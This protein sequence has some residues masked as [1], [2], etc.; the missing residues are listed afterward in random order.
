[1]NRLMIYPEGGFESALEIGRI[2]RDAAAALRPWLTDI[3]WLEIDLNDSD[4]SEAV[5]DAVI[6]SNVPSLKITGSDFAP[7]FLPHLTRALRQG[8]LQQLTFYL[9]QGYSVLLNAGGEALSDFCC[10]LRESQLASLRLETLG[11]TRTA[12]ASLRA[13]LQALQG[14]PTLRFLSITDNVFDGEQREAASEA[15]AGLIAANSP[16]LRTLRIEKCGFDWKALGRIFDALCSNTYLIE[17]R[18]CQEGHGG[19]FPPPPDD[20]INGCFVRH[21]VLPA[22]RACTALRQLEW[23]SEVV[24][25]EDKRQRCLGGGAAAVGRWWCRRST[26]SWPRDGGRT[27][28]PGRRRDRRRSSSTPC[29]DG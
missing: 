7:S 9:D 19:D 29:D 15:V 21:R 3:D 23:D 10:A 6:R 27:A 24:L 4:F 11:L 25:D 17:L 26:T 14:H 22:V 1:M 16:A 20:D 13:A 28:A 18:C 2:V 5:A 12:P 8:A